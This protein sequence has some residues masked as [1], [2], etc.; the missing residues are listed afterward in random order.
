MKKTDLEKLYR[1]NQH[2]FSERPSKD[3]WT[4]LEHRLDD[5]YGRRHNRRMNSQYPLAM[6]AALLILVVMIGS[7][8]ILLNKQQGSIFNSQS[9][10]IEF[11]EMPYEE[12]PSVQEVIEFTK[13][14]QERLA[15]PIEEG[16][17]GKKIRIS[18]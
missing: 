2:K 5:H 11:E 8:T 3:A 12:V 1:A 7:I 17:D 6:V 14:Y 15:K 13:R 16:D 4:R 10:S 9:A 18:N